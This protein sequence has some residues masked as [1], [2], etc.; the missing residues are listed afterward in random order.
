MPFILQPQSWF[1]HWWSRMVFLTVLAVSFIYPFYTSV[2]GGIPSSLAP[3]TMFVNVIYV[4]DLFLLLITATHDGKGTTDILF[5]IFSLTTFLWHNILSNVGFA[6][7]VSEIAAVKFSESGFILDII[8]TV[9]LELFVR[10]V[11]SGKNKR[12][13]DIVMLNRV[14]KLKEVLRQLSQMEEKFN[15]N[16]TLLRLFKYLLLLFFGSLWLGACLYMIAC[17]D[18]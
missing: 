3:F 16:V 11:F 9:P 10:A 4:L 13:E 18:E 14:I 2:A 7:T 15:V 8:A 12:L 5:S 17:G 6:K 1:L